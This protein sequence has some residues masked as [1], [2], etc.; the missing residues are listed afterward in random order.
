MRSAARKSTT[1]GGA[2]AK[3]TAN[4]TATATS[5]FDHL[6]P[7]Q[8]SNINTRRRLTARLYDPSGHVDESV[9]T[10]LDELLCDARDRDHWKSTRLDRRTLQL[11]YRTAYHFHAAEVEVVSAYRKAERRRE[12]MHAQGRAVDFRL[13]GVQ[14]ATLAAYLRTV[15]RVGVGVYTH[16]KTRF[17]H[18]DVREHSYHWLDASPPRRHWR[19]R[20][21]SSKTLPALDAEYSPK[22]DWPEGLP[23][24]GA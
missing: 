18:L 3:P 16:P 17:V 22:S 11:L 5:A 12:G 1:T 24:P 8:F 9:A 23:A 14:A 10:Q 21:I 19:E 15:P 20:N 2:S 6:L 7:V 13:P 4:A